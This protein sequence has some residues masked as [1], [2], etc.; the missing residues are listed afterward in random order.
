MKLVLLALQKLEEAA[1][2][3]EAGVAGDDQGLH[4]GV[5]FL[6]GHV[7]WNSRLLCEAF[8]FGEQ[9]AI[10]RFGP[11][12]DGAFVQRFRLV[13]DN[14]VEIEIDGVAEPLTAW[15]G[16]VGIIER[17]QAR[18][19]FVVSTAVV[20][21]FEALGEA[22]ALEL[23]IFVVAGSGFEDD[24][25]CFAVAD[26]YGVDDSRAGV[27]GNGDAIDE[28][29]Y[30]LGEIHFQQRFRTR[31][32]EDVAVL[33]KA[34]EAAFAEIEEAGFDGVGELVGLDVHFFLA[35][36][37]LGC[38]FLS[39]CREGLHWEKN[40]EAGAVGQ[41]HYPVGDFVDRVFLYFLSA[42]QAIGASDAGKQ[43]AQVVENLGG[44]GD[45][46]ARVAG[47]VLL[48]DRDGGGDAVD[49]VGVGFFDALQKLPRI[50]G[51][52]FDIAALAFGVDGVEGE[53]RFAGA[54]D[55]GDHRQL[56]VRDLK[57]DVFEVMNPGPANNNAFRRH[58]PL[59][60]SVAVEEGAAPHRPVR[61]R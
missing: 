53:R 22:K 44:G 14:E 25:S 5:E 50:G 35:A 7:E 21:A 15:A 52:R 32:L 18:L 37:F 3:G 45:G 23:F 54:G 11:G 16:A 34:V 6:P 30:G 28:G 49:Q 26:F 60:S 20:F 29:E 61:K 56:V 39:V 43:Q 58:L 10:F 55:T 9:G 1:D 46:G 33:K 38:F 48:F 24:F 13:G 47:G 31:E 17:E 12:F 2:A 57:I 41:S 36:R 51:K 19:G 8:E 40:V 59:S 27:G 4:F 42:N